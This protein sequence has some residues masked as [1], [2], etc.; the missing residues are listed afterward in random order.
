MVAPEMDVAHHVAWRSMKCVLVDS[1]ETTGRRTHFRSDRTCLPVEPR[2]A[3]SARQKG[4]RAL[5]PP[6]ARGRSVTGIDDR[7][8][9]LRANPLQGAFELCTIG[10]GKVRA[11]HRAGEQTVA[12][13]RDTVTVDRDVARGVSRHVN[14]GEAERPDVQG[15]AVGQ[16]MIGRG[17]LLHA[18]PEHEPVLCSAIVDGAL[19]RVDGDRHR[20]LTDDSGD[21]TDVV[22]VRVGQPDRVELGPIVAHGLEQALWLVAWIDEHRATSGLVDDEICVLLQ[23][24]HGQRPNDHTAYPPLDSSCGSRW[25]FLSAVRYFSAAIAAVV[26][27]PTAVVT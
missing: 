16:V 15:V 2:D 10:E 22:H 1:I 7:V 27:S 8:F 24:A 4:V 9:R 25:P 23:R 11:A 26:A 6:D 14:D 13:E 19:A 5:L 18:E 12:H 17:R 20:G 21:G 3:D